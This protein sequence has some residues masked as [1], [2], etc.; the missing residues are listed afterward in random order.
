MAQSKNFPRNS[1]VAKGESAP[2]T[3]KVLASKLNLDPATVSV[4]LNNVPGRS[5]PERTRERIRSMARELNYHPSYIARSLR[6]RRTMMVGI[7][8]PVLSEGYHSEV[9]NGIFRELIEQD[10]FNFIATHR[11]RMELV[12]KYPGMMQSRGAEGILA[13]DTHLVGPLPVPVVSIAGHITIPGVTNVMLD[14]NAAA[15]LTLRHLYDLGHRS[16]AFMHGHPDSTDSDSRWEALQSA[17]Q[18]LGIAID[19]KLT[20]HIDEDRT[21]PELGYPVVERLLQQN[22]K[23]TAMVCFND[24]AAI[25]VIRALHDAQI[26]VPQDVSIIGF[27]DVPYSAFH[28]PRLTT[29]RQP[30]AEMG[31]QA[32]RL[33]IAQMNGQS[34]P[35]SEVMVTPEL[36]VRESTGPVAS[37]RSK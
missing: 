22:Q 35:Q 13:I 17:A 32:A 27:D 2:V 14:H 24:V 36:I 21:T 26:R 11:H 28:S 25:G 7:L 8:T 23:F 30:L 6:N 29:I 3:L 1:P 4:V 31:A 18:E 15:R 16:I 34:E 37:E 9:M 5:I 20:I 12:A 33:L 19:P 10:Y